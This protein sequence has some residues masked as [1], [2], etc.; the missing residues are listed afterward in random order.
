M[1]CSFL[2]TR[3]LGIDYGKKKIGLALSDEDG[4]FAFPH[5]VYKNDRDF[6]EHL[7]TLVNKESVHTAVLG[8]SQNYAGDDNL[9]MEDIR[10]FITRLQKRIPALA[11]ELQDERLTSQ[12]AA[13]QFESKVKSRKP[14]TAPVLDASAAAL[15]LQIYLDSKRGQNV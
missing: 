5:G 4:E 11:V 14:K 3:Y 7:I 12:Q 8:E 15:I 13:R 9:I 1:V 2:M 6:I 10:N